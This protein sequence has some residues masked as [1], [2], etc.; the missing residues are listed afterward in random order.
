MNYMYGRHRFYLK[1]T[2]AITKLFKNALTILIYV[3]TNHTP[4]YL[5]FYKE[6]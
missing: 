4:Y 6:H 3:L 2:Y 5:L 1:Y